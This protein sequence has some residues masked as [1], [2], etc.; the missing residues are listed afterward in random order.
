MKKQINYQISYDLMGE[1]IKFNYI[2]IMCAQ[3]MIL[4]QDPKMIF[5]KMKGNIIDSNVFLRGLIL[6][7]EKFKH[8]YQT[9]MNVDKM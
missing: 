2:N 4:R 8:Q 5:E 3:E 7:Y 1:I 6:S 9:S